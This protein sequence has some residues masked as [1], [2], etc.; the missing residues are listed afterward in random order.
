MYLKEGTPMATCH[1]SIATCPPWQ[2]RYAYYPLKLVM[3]GMPI[4]LVTPYIPFSLV[5]LIIFVI[6]VMPIKR[7]LGNCAQ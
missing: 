5:V 4:M 1:A 6:L 2:S 7:T 3:P